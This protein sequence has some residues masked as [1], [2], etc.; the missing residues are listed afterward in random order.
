MYI[1]TTAT[2]GAH[3]D[4]NAIFRRRH[5]SVVCSNND[6][7]VVPIIRAYGDGRSLLNIYIHSRVD[8]Y[9]RAC[10][11]HKVYC[12]YTMYKKRVRRSADSVSNNS[13][14]SPS[15]ATKH[16]GGSGPTLLRIARQ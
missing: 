4:E 3:L 2:N 12:I 13:S 8:A 14:S 16:G 10:D 9:A 7:D 6:D 15:L 11:V 5:D 1:I